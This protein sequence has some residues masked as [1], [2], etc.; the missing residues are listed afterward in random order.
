M[1]LNQESQWNNSD[2]IVFLSSR[3]VEISEEMYENLCKK[4]TAAS[5]A[6]VFPLFAKNLKGRGFLNANLDPAWINKEVLKAVVFAADKRAYICTT[7]WNFKLSVVLLPT[8]CRS[9]CISRFPAGKMLISCLQLPNL[10]SS[11][12][13]FQSRYT[14]VWGTYIMC[15]PEVHKVHPLGILPGYGPVINI[16]TIIISITLIIIIYIII[17][18]M[19]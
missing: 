17:I 2:A 13:W 9:V 6:A 19:S 4:K 5:G 18:Y 7:E 14:G 11:Y 15:T 3:H 8:L 16:I 1:P 12:C 10:C